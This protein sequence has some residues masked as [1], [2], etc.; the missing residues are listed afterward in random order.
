MGFVRARVELWNP[1]RAERKLEVELTVDT[2]AMY[3]VLPRQTLEELGFKPVGKRRFKLA[4]GRVIER[5]V[6]IAGVGAKG[7]VAYTTVVF[8]EREDEPVLGVTALE[9]L[10]LEVDP[11]TREL[12][13][14]ELLLLGA[15]FSH[16]SG[17]SEVGGKPNS[18]N[19]SLGRKFDNYKN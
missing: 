14:A 2:G 9:E 4:D 6:G 19:P 15:S 5:E 18:S 11:A 17:G 1:E 10:G 16:S 12:R 3:T 7:R 8:G 13:P